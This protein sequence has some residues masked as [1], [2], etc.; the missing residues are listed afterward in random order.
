MDMLERRGVH[1][2]R[3]V[4]VVGFDGIPL[5]KVVRPSLTT[6]TQP[7]RRLGETAVDM[8]VERLADPDREPRS[9]MLPVMQTRRASCGCPD[10]T[11]R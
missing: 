2:P 10:P 4:A 8:L 6:V 1:V 5:G 11:P 9:E 7:M 3:D